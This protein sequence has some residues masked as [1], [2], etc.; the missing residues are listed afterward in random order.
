MEILK[1]LDEF[2]E[3]CQKCRKVQSDEVKYETMSFV[4]R[5]TIK[6]IVYF[7]YAMLFHVLKTII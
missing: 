4:R 7:D 3:T 6:S 1:R 5:K 2:D